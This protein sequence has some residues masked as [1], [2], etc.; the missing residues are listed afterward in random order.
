VS[1]PSEPARATDLG[2]RAD[3][4]FG[5]PVMR[6]ARDHAHLAWQTIG[7]LKRKP[8]F[9]EHHTHHGHSPSEQDRAGAFATPQDG[10]AHLVP[11]PEQDP[12][13]P[14]ELG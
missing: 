13:R 10:T 2:E 8:S 1:G 5:G 6:V 4:D 9:L 14:A 7:S 3:I 12:G 11:L